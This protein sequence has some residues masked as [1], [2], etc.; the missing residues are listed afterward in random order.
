MVAQSI[1][2]SWHNPVSL[3]QGNGCS[4]E[5]LPH[6][7]VV[8]IAD[9][10]AV[11]AEREERLRAQFGE[12]C[13]AWFWIPAGEA[14][15]RSA[16]ELC[17]TI[18]PML[19]G[20][21]QVTLIGIGGGTTLDL[22]KVVRYRLTDTPAELWARHW[23]TNTLPE[24]YER[25]PLWLLPTTSGTGSEVTRWATLWDSD[26]AQPIKL[27]W[28]P[29]DGFAD[30]AWVDP[31][32]TLSCPV[33]IS[34]DCGLDTLAHALE[35]IWNH[36]ANELSRALALEAAQYAIAA[37]PRVLTNLDD[38][39]ARAQ[40]SRASVMAGLAMSQTQTALAHALSYDITLHEG[41]PHGEACAMW[42]PMCWDLALGVSQVCDTTLAAV[43]PNG[44]ARGS[45]ALRNWLA[46][47]GIQP[48]DLL[49]EPRGLETLKLELQSS[50]GRNF[51]AATK[52]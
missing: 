8:V 44:A 19:T 33:R 25:Y 16:Q 6:G 30:C 40:M 49:G 35:S 15:V 52:L 10:C 20:S 26:V 4:H 18:W 51:I 48:R 2:L 41:I 34:R 39:D 14:S 13:K 42:L 38:L 46:V 50:R 12:R 3:V 32:L 37:L 21:H 36:R 27:S 7:S 17:A 29:Q 45:Q 11:P 22:A 43:F 47:L 5:V 23:R 1:H 31:E 28:A 9:R 24:I